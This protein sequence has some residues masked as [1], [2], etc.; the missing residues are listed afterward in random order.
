MPAATIHRHALGLTWVEQGGTARTSH[1][2]QDQGR[3][4]LIDPWDDADALTEAAE[5]GPPKAVIQLLD[6]HNRN[7]AAIATR[8]GVPHLRVPHDVPNSPFEIDPI[9]DRPKWREVALWWPE[10]SA[11][12]VAEALGTVPAFAVGRRAGVHPMLRLT[13]P[14]KALKRRLPESLL[15]GH[16][17]PIEEDAA[18]AIGEALKGARRDIPK[19]LLTLPKLARGNG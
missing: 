3:T 7:C 6:R 19:L 12:I 11:L 14:S 8:L 5:L 18:A 2:L 4:W 15:V 1:A 17:P 16:G 9:V 10:R 13:P